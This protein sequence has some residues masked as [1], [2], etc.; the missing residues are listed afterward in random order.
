MNANN[1]DTIYGTKVKYELRYFT[2]GSKSK[3]TLPSLAIGQSEIG[4]LEAI[5]CKFTSVEK[6]GYDD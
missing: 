4:Q 3:I 6:G 1:V 2:F 5:D